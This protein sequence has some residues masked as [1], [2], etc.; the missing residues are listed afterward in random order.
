MPR[1]RYVFEEIQGHS[2]QYGGLLVILA[3]GLKTPHNQG[4]FGLPWP[5]DGTAMS[6]ATDSVDTLI[7]PGWIV[8]VVPRDTV[9]PD[10][11]IALPGDR[12]ARG[13]AVARSMP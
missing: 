2:G 3:R 8:P 5:G 1:A 11:S 13:F 10:Y 6:T 12:N 4:R 9:L 7:H